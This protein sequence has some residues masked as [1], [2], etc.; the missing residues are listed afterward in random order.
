MSPQKNRKTYDAETRRRAVKALAAGSGHRALAGAL[1]LPEATARQWA[2][3]YAV[4]GASAVMNAG[5]THRIYPYEL[6]LSVVKDRF[7]HGMSVRDVMIKYGVPSES[8]VKTWCR[9]YREHGAEALID[10]PR[11]RKPK[12]HDPEESE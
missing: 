8:S 1:G 3:A 7:E 9:Q 12:K 4:G 10:R 11:G 5:A 2:R 6:K